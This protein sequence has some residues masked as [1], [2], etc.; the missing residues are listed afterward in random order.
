MTF[1]PRASF[2]PYRM[3][4]GSLLKDGDTGVLLGASVARRLGVAIGDEVEMTMLL[5]AS[6]RLIL[7]DGGYETY[8]LTVR[9]L[10][11]FGA[12]DSAFVTRS[13]M[14][15][16]VGDETVASVLII[17]AV[18]HESAPSIAAT[19]TRGERGVSAR[20][21]MDDSLYLRSSVKAAVSG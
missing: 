15:G 13:F 12:S 16:E 4:A 5:S 19:V 3:T 10:V 14:A 20:A 21:W 11:G 2:H 6:P 1:E 17:H 8:T 18:D 7:D 9:G